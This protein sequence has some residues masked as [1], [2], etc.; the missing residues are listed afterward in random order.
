MVAV[1]VGDE[2]TANLTG[3]QIA[4]EKLL[5]SAFAAV[6]E[7]NFGA[8]GKTKGDAGHVARSGGDA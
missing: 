2:N 3:A 6:E 4:S 8:L 1:H 7:P 5:L